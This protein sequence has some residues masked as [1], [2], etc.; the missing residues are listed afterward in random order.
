M[1]LLFCS[2]LGSRGKLFIVEVSV[3]F[4]VSYKLR[5]FKESLQKSNY[6]SVVWINVYDKWY[7]FK[8]NFWNPPVA[9]VKRGLNKNSLVHIFTSIIYW[10]KRYIS[11]F[12]LW[13]ME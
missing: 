3:I 10:E 2:V 1:F 5:L 8:Y 11:D 4:V 9:V 7:K 12:F 6:T 13:T